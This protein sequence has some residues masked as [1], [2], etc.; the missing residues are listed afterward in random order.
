MTT[1]TV[2]E[3]AV[4]N[5]YDLARTRFDRIAARLSLD[6]ATRTLLRTPLRELRVQIPIR[7]DDGRVRVFRGLRVQH[8]DARGPFKGGVRLSP[9]GSED[10]VRA[11]AMAMTW[12]CAIADLPL[13]GAKGW[14]ACDPRSLSPREQEQICRGWVRQIAGNLGASVDVPAPD[15][16][17]SATHMAW[18][19]DEYE[20]M[21][22]SRVP[23]FVTGKPLALGGSAGRVEATGHGVVTALQRILGSEE[24]G[25]AR[26]SASIQGFGKVGQH[27]CRRL[28]ELG[29]I[30]R[31]VSCWNHVDDVTARANHEGVSLRDAAY[32]VAISRV[33]EACSLRGWV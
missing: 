14:I 10:D 26:V 31:A 23:G 21:R 27:A 28:V 16:M 24:L 5:A 12:K 9:T 20:V 30:A 29:G 3:S 11:L 17:S 18:M 19:L 32:R 22:G 6:E 25:T 15:V 8:N 33:A 7:M 4:D 1:L 2:P 13:G